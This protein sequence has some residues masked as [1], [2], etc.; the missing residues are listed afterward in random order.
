MAREIIWI[1]L[2]KASQDKCALSRTLAHCNGIG[3]EKELKGGREE[4]TAPKSFWSNRSQ[5]HSEF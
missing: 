3:M 1:G 2:E 5:V 4:W